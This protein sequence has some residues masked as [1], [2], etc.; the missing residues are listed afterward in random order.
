MPS[1]AARVAR[2]PVPGRPEPRPDRIP[3]LRRLAPRGQ[4]AGLVL[5]LLFALLA[6]AAPLIA[7]Y[8]PTRPT[9]VPFE[10]PS[11][12][13]WLGTDD[14]GQDIFSQLV[15]GTR[16][17]LTI[18]VLAALLSTVIG[19][20]IGCVAGYHGR[21]LGAV[22]MR[23]TDLVLVLPFL[24]L[25]IL[26]A[27]YVGPSFLTLVLVLGGLGWARP[28]RVIRAQALTATTTDYIA[29]ARGQGAGPARILATHLLPA[30]LG[31]VVAE[32]V[33][34]ASRTIQ[35]AAALAFL[36]LGDPTETSWGS[37]LFYAQSRGAFLSPS[38]LWWVVPPGLCICLTAL[39]FGLV[40]YGVEERL[41]PRLRSLQTG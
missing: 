26:L 40:G 7:R 32:F 8:S 38:W 21:R 22:L 13:H 14:I 29:A 35:A 37:M 3:L 20:V 39:G 33:I 23:T 18:A 12:H 41:N 2:A 30:V 24:P 28:A 6:L 17:S 25:I 34:A 9:G 1:L 27:A 15:W 4:G 31:I 36:G 5:V 16:A 19:T 10:S 11:S